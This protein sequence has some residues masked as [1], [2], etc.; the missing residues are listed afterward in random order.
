MLLSPSLHL[1]TLVKLLLFEYFCYDKLQI[2]EDKQ[3][4]STFLEQ[5]LIQFLQGKSKEIQAAK[6]ASKAA[7][8]K[9]KKKKWSKGR[10]KEKLNNKVLM[11]KKA[12]TSLQKEVPKMKVITISRVSEALGVSGSVAKNCIRYLSKEGLA[13][14]VVVSSRMLVFTALESAQ[15]EEEAV[16]STTKASKKPAKAEVADKE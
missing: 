5:I 8:S 9:G 6:A 7:A 11:D 16:V 4:P 2:L 1:A 15:K 10:V 3:Y 12:M 14:P 13:T